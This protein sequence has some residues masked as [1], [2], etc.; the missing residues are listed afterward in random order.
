MSDLKGKTLI[1]GCGPR[2]PKTDD[3]WRVDILG[4]NVDQVWDLNKTPWPW[5]DNTFLHANAIHLIEHLKD[6][7][8]FMNE[9]HR[10]LMP[11]GT[12]YIETPLAG[13]DTDLEY[14]D[15]T[16]IRCYRPHTFINY[17]TIEGEDKFKYGYKCWGNLHIETKDSVMR[18]HAM[19]I[20]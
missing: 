18:I 10:V 8:S 13:G 2:W 12:L 4:H 19:P 20:K 5:E 9:C 15:P 1:L 6:L 11:G 16:H 17:M 14:A 7:K 3:N